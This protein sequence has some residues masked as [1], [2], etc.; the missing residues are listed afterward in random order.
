VDGARWLITALAPSLFWV[1]GVQ[2]LHGAVVVGLIIG[3]QL[4]VEG[5]VPAR[6]RATGQTLL[7]TVM[8][9]GAVLSHLWAGAALGH[10][11]ADAPYLIS[12]PV[13]IGLGICAWFVLR[14]QAEG[15]GTDGS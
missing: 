2:L 13:A 12:G 1:F 9:T 11:G 8:S 4:Y 5:E 10:L 6:L 3:M 7:G 15:A 14:A